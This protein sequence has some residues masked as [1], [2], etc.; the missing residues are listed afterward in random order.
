[1][2]LGHFDGV[3]LAHWERKWRMRADKETQAVNMSPSR[4]AQMRLILKSL[5]E[6]D[7]AMRALFAR[8]YG[9]TRLQYRALAALGHAFRREIFAPDGKA[10]AGQPDRLRTSPTMS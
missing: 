2:Y 7:G 8:Y 4:Q 9:L 5:R 10:A 6:G 1:M 3:G